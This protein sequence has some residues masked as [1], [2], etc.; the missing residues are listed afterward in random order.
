MKHRTDRRAFFCTLAAGAAGMLA[1]G[2]AHAAR[3]GKGKKAAEKDAEWQPLFNGKDLTGWKETGKPGTWKAE[4]G[5]LFCTGG[6]GGWLSTAKEYANFEIALEFRL[7]PEGNSGVFLRHPGTGDGAYT[8]MEIQV[9]DDYAKI[10]DNLRP[11]QYCGSIYDV[12]AAAPGVTKKDP[13]WEK[14]AAKKPG[15]WQKMDILCD[16]RKVKITLNDEVIVDA[17]L[18]DYKD[19]EKKH[20]GLTRTTGYIGL[21]NHGSRLDYRNIRI[22]VLPEK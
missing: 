18:D 2:T 11:V 17:N 15:E 14:R 16:G 5:I 22:K 13:K 8:G 10:H 6:G 20:A 3:A 4:D 12:V 19:K 1:A 7:P 21:Q 9:L